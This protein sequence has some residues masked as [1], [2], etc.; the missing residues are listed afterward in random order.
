MIDNTEPKEHQSQKGEKKETVTWIKIVH[1]T[2]NGFGRIFQVSWGWLFPVF[3]AI[4][5]FFIPSLG[6]SF[7][8][9]P[10][11]IGLAVSILVS[12]LIAVIWLFYGF[13][14]TSDKN[15]TSSELQKGTSI[16]IAQVIFLTAVVSYLAAIGH[17]AWYFAVPLV[18]A[19]V[20]TF[21]T[22]HLAINNATQK[23]F[24]DQ[25]R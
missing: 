22:A 4:A 10:W 21:I 6:L 13:T 15:T 12:I 7:M 3:M 2:G 25:G 8:T 20:D 24:I 1:L 5:G 16:S 18:T 14:W 9:W 19:I 23:P 17:F 11:T